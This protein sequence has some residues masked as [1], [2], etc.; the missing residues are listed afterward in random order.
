MRPLIKPFYA[1]ESKGEKI[2]F[3]GDLVHVAAVQFPQ[4][5]VTI[6]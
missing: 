2:V 5:S 6:I 1:L 4:L 3:V